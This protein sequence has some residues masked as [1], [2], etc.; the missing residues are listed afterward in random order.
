MK[1]FIEITVYLLFSIYIAFQIDY[2]LERCFDSYKMRRAQKAIFWVIF[3]A[4]V[5]L[6]ALGAFLPNSLLKFHIQ[7]FGNIWLGYLMFLGGFMLI[8]HIIRVLVI[9]IAK[10]GCSPLNKAMTRILCLA[11]VATVFVINIYGTIHAQNITTSKY[12]ITI[13]KDAGSVSKLKIVLISDLHLGVNSNIDMTK[14]MVRKINDQNADIVVVA[15]DI[16]S[17]SYDG[18]Q[19]QD[20][21]AKVLSGIRSEYGTYAVYGNH[22]VV[23]TLFG[24]F[25][26]SPISKAIR[27]S[28]MV[29]FMRKSDFT[30]LTDKSVS[31]VGNIQLVGRIDGEKSGDGTN[32]RKAGTSLSKSLNKNDPIIFAEHE[33]LDFKDLASA[34]ADLV[35]SGHTHDGQIFPGN[36]VTAIL[37]ENACGLKKINGILSIVSAG[38]GYYGPPMRVGTNSE[39]T[40]INISFK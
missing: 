4:L 26:I 37:S 38:V 20:A 19:D 16:F 32:M 17:S 34:G 10:D 7:A 39:I 33:P 35:L 12:S 15:G 21:Y 18:L 6:P 22:D 24:G 9:M 14:R 40:V 11:V 30:V 13:D 29:S 1:V 36:I 25:A 23:E 3:A 5:S 31:P 2:W 27:S 28:D 8:L